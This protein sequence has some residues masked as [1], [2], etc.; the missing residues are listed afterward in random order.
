[1]SAASGPGWGR[2][3]GW[4]PVTGGEFLPLELHFMHRV[5]QDA[6]LEATESYWLRRA[7]AFDAVGTP[8][9]DEIAQ[10]CRNRATLAEVSVTE[11]A[12]TLM[13]MANGAAA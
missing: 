12:E 4:R 8:A 7:A 9:C 3:R 1:M 13:A 6:W 10:A 11:F 2:P 5:L